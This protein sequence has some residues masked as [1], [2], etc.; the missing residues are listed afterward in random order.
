MK[1]IRILLGIIIGILAVAGLLTLVEKGAEGASITSFG[2]A[3]WYMVVTLTTVGYGD[4]YPVTVC[5]KILGTVV[6]LASV[7]LLG[8]I[9]ANVISFLNKDVKPFLYLKKHKSE[10]WYVFSEYNKKTAFL[11]KDIRKSSKG[12]FIC[13]SSKE[14]ETEDGIILLESSFSKIIAQKEN[15][16]T[17][18]I[19]LAGEYESDYENYSVYCEHIAP[20]VKEDALPFKCYCMTEYV[21]E[22]YPFNLVLFNTCENISRLYWNSYPLK[23][24]SEQDEKVVLIG[25]GKYGDYILKQALERNVVKAHQSVEYHVFGDSSEFLQKHLYLGDYFSVGK[26]S[27]TVDSLFFYEDSWMS[28]PE[29]LRAASRI[30]ICNDDGNDNLCVLSNYRKY[31]ECS[32][33]CKE[34]HI[35]YP[36]KIKDSD[37]ESFGTV[38]EVYT[39]DLVLKRKLSK[40]AEDMNNRYVKENAGPDWRHLSEFKRQSNLAVADHMAIK[41]EILGAKTEQEAFQNYSSLSLDD[42]AE[43]WKLEHDR[44][45]RFHILNNWHYAAVRNDDAREH[46]LL[47]PFEELSFEEQ[48]K[49]GYSWE[50]MKEI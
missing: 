7:G 14:E 15:L 11:I 22:K 20:F 42:K 2:K 43:L 26:K 47:V 3:L 24:S 29:V 48:K 40:V 6:V 9:F 16:S 4:M 38:E 45:M 28:R 34:I 12:V 50:I 19:I 35:L 33:S 31:F 44:W 27:E 32:G 8:F 37:A 18:H 21:P 30:I 25:T 13:L 17:L 10:D 36:E 39:E 49:D 46:N 5:G 23:I 1:K 41:M